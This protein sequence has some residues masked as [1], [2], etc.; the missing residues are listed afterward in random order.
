MFVQS[1][2]LPDLLPYY[3]NQL[4]GVYSKTEVK[5]LFYWICENKH[6]LNRHEVLL[7]TLRLS[8]SELLMHR[9]VVKRL[10]KHEPIQHILGE[11]I[12]YGLNIQCDSSALIPRPETEELV[13]LIVKNMSGNETVLDVGTGTAC[14][15]LSIKHQHPK[16]RV[17]AIDVSEKALELAKKNS[18]NLQLDIHFL[19]ADI[20]LSELS[21]LPPFDIIVSNPP[22]VLESDKKEM[23]AN[24]LD[25]DPHL[26]LFVPDENPLKFYKRIADVAQNKLKSG[27][28]LYFEIH[29]KFGDATRNMLAE[30]GFQS[31]KIIKDLQ[32]K[33]RMISAINA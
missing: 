21:E 10:L 18:Q 28:E 11:T 33:E 8:E 25:Y 23:Q 24:V 6:Q 9:Q 19:L 7:S 20:L 5:S 15:P 1:N 27:G 22:Y 16:S 26:A 29:E 2:L 3:Q 13:D 31:I 32:G 30:K 14:I 4:K 12:F 17:Y